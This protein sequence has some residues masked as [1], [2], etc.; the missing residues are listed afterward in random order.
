LS[1]WLRPP[2]RGTLALALLFVNLVLWFALFLPIMLLK[3]ALPLAPARERLGRVLESVATGW[4]AGNARIVALTQRTR[5]DVELPPG[6]GPGGWYLVLCNHRGW[7]DIVLLQMLF[8]RRIP[9]LKFFMKRQLLWLPMIGVGCWALDFPIMQR[10]TRAQIAARPQLAGRD[11]ETTRRACEKFRRRPTAIMNFVEGTRFTPEKHARQG[12]PY[13]RLLRPR[14]GG[15]AFV[16]G[17]MGG[18]FDAILDV[19]LHYGPGEPTVWRFLT[20][21]IERIAV[22]VRAVEIPEWTLAGRYESD[23]AFRTRF[24][25]WLSALW[26]DKDRELVALSAGAAEAGLPA[27]SDGGAWL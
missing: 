27:S 20:G 17:A 10:H 19:T 1:S 26:A 16:L 3:L 18:L 8:N 9:V 5:M 2:L 23:P 25:G 12:S 6:L 15:V 22:R 7:M 11:L 24:Q 13:A 4:V 14:A 21:R